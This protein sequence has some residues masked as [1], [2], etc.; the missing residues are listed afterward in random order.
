MK[1]LKLWFPEL[2]EVQIKILKRILI[3][4]LELSKEQINKLNELSTSK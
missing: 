2:N 3:E 4:E 1:N